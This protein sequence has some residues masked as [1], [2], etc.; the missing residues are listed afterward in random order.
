[1][2]KEDFNKFLKGITE[3]IDHVKTELM[4]DF[5]FD[6]FSHDQ[7][8]GQQP[9]TPQSTSSEQSSTPPS[10][11]ASAPASQAGEE[12]SQ[13]RES[14]QAPD[15]SESSTENPVQGDTSHRDEHVDKW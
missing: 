6:I 1:M 12:S 8:E 2:Y 7:E 14:P 10:E 4:P 3:A 9:Y 15:S 5:D 11:S 13:S